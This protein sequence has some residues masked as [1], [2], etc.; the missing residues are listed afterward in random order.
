M[1]ITIFTLFAVLYAA[2]QINGQTTFLCKCIT[3][4]VESLGATGACCGRVG[5]TGIGAACAI[6]RG[7]A[8]AW[9]ACCASEGQGVS[10]LA[11]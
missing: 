9:E 11:T 7:S 8:D 3:N 4:G 5:G 2:T 1:Q 10:C 6:L